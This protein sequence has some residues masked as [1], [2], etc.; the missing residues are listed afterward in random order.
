M[1]DMKGAYQVPIW[2]SPSLPALEP[3]E[4]D[5]TPLKTYSKGKLPG[6]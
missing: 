6:Y 4:Y 3:I 1:E 2:E 5:V